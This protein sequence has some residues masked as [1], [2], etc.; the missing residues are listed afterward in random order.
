MWWNEVQLA[1]AMRTLSAEA[2]YFESA[3]RHHLD[4]PRSKAVATGP[5]SSTGPAGKIDNTGPLYV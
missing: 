4:R 5:K 1:I 3:A 2:R